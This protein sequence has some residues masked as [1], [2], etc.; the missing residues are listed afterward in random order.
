MEEIEPPKTEKEDDDE[1][2]EDESKE[3]EEDGEKQDEESTESTEDEPKQDEA[4]GSEEVADA[5]DS[6][7]AAV[8]KEYK[9]TIVPHTF[10]VDDIAET[11]VGARLLSK[12]QKKDAGKRMKALD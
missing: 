8:E 3:G 12:D 5:G 4:E 1:K 7:E 9:E 10:T 11:P 2:K 6:E